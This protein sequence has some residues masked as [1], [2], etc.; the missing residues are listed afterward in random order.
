MRLT[1]FAIDE[2]S[3]LTYLKDVICIHVNPL[4]GLPSTEIFFDFA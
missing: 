2:V 4:E 3:L 1:L